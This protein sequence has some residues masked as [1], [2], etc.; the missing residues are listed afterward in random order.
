MIHGSLTLRV[1]ARFQKEADQPASAR[2]DTRKLVQPV[3]KPKGIS[4]EVVH[5]FA[6]TDDTRPDGTKPDRRDLRPKDLFQRTPRNVNV[7]NYV[8]RGY[9]DMEKAI[10]K[11]IPKD[12]GYDTV[13]NLSQYL[14]E[15]GGGGD[16]PPVKNE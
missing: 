4:K 7:L 2:K 6:V 10:R 15:T 11:Q 3:N 8:E 13:S 14:I 5:D 1:A 16:T 12:K 9:Q